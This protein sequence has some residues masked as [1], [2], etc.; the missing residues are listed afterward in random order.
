MLPFRLS[1]LQ[2]NFFGGLKDFYGKGP[3]KKLFC[4]GGGEG[5]PEK[6]GSGT[7]TK[8]LRLVALHAPEK[9]EGVGRDLPEKDS[10][11]GKSVP[12][13]KKT[14]NTEGGLSSPR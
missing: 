11:G 1:T 10:D 9:K 13:E 8:R 7:E 5:A 4:R 14:A 6:T 3:R 2:N 12:P